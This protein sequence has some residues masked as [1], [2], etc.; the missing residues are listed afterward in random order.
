MTVDR[1][2]RSGHG[3]VAAGDDGVSGQPAPN[4]EP[5]RPPG[6]TDRP[7]RPASPID[8]PDPVS[9]ATVFWYSAVAAILFVWF[10]FGW[11]VLR[12]GFIDSVGEALGTGFGLL[13]AVS[14]IGAVRRIRADR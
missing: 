4:E 8:R 1:E 7:G 9:R 2:L 6:Q 3:A 11:L 5:G 12:Q 14:V 13:L 10:L